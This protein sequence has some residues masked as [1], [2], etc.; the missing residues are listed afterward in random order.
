MKTGTLFL[1]VKQLNVSN[2]Q[3]TGSRSYVFFFLELEKDS[4]GARR[5]SYHYCSLVEGTRAI[6]VHAPRP[7]PQ[8]CYG[9]GNHKDNATL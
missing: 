7:Q 3:A 6:A 2:R 8:V 9:R 5:R 4:K 1:I